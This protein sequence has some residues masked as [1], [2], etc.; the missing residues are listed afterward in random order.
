METKELCRYL[1]TVAGDKVTF[2]FL[3]RGATMKVAPIELELKAVNLLQVMSAVQMQTGLRFVYRDGVVFLT[4]KEQMTPAMSVR[5]YDLRGA[6]TPLHNFPGPRLG[7]RSPSEEAGPLY[8]PEEESGNTVCGF[9]AEQIEELIKKHVTPEL[10]GDKATLSN[11]KGMFI[12][13]TTL[14]GHRAIAVLLDELGVMELPRTV[15]ER[16]RPVPPRRSR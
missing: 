14:A 2:L 1:S 16:V 11:Q 12:V 4:P 10:W 9:T 15:S 6:V 13:R 8:P 5:I 3:D 7:L